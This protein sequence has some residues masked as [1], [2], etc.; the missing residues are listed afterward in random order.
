[1]TELLVFTVAAFYIG[2]FAATFVRQ[3][4]S[5]DHKTPAA[6]ATYERLAQPVWVSWVIQSSFWPVF[7]LAILGMACLRRW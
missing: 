5:W 1:M 7:A 2:G 3:V 4:Q 6:A